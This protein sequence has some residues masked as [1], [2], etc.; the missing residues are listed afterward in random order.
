[1]AA[2]VLYTAAGGDPTIITWPDVGPPYERWTFTAGTAL[3]VAG[4]I[5]YGDGSITFEDGRTFPQKTSQGSTFY[6]CCYE[7]TPYQRP[8]PLPPEPTSPTPPIIP[9]PVVIPPAVNSNT[10]SLD[11]GATL[12][13]GFVVG[14]MTATNNPT[15]WLITA[16]AGYFAIDNSGVITLTAAGAINLANQTGTA[17]LTV[18]ASNSGGSGSGMAWIN[19][20]PAPFVAP[21]VPTGLTVTPM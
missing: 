15:S 13:T 20:Q 11:T 9:P 21:S 4:L 10:F 16:G 7:L 14:T 2:I 18:Q 3:A 6:H 5:G 1:M 19:Y 12:P 8:V 17:I